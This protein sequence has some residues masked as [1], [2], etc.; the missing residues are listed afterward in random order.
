VK[1]TLITKALG[2]NPTSIVGANPNVVMGVDIIEV[3]T[4]SNPKHHRG[5][6]GGGGHV[7]KDGSI[8]G[9]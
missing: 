8:H 4:T 2:A 1:E 5:G 6:R 7:I 9:W 3:D